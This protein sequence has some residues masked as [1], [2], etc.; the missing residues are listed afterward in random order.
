MI[1]LA[2]PIPFRLAA[3]IALALSALPAFLL[4]VNLPFYR[5]LPMNRQG[6]CG[7]SPQKKR[8]WKP[9]SQS[10]DGSAT[11]LPLPRSWS[12]RGSHSWNTPV[13]GNRTGAPHSQL[14]S[15]L[16][17]ARNEAE[18]IVPALQSVLANPDPNLEI[19]VLDDHSTDAT[20]DRVRAIA[21]SD[22]R[23]RLLSGDQ[24][25]PGWCGKQHACWQLARA[26]RGD[27]LIFM[28]ADVRLSADAL[29]R[30]R[31]HF[32][33]KPKTHLLSGV[34]RQITLGFAEKL[35]I[36]LIHFI[37]LGF[38]PMIAARLSLWPAFAAGCG[39]FF[40]ARR[41]AYFASDGHRA[42]RGSLHD[43]I[44]LPRTF[45]RHRF[46]TE[47]FD[48]TDIAACRMYM[49]CSAVW[50]GLGKNA[51]EGL[52]HP[53][54]ILPWTLVL[55]G[56]QVLPWLLLMGSPWLNTPQDA[57]AFTVVLAA[58]SLSLLPRLVAC[59]A[60]SQSWLGAV[61]HPLGISVLLAIQWQALA[62]RWRGQPMVWRGRR[63]PQAANVVA[64]SQSTA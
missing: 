33:H 32:E 29:S 6:G 16:I 61:L 50:H 54:A 2:G 49:S 28:D 58:A 34:P 13:P 17:P 23:V 12:Q 42:I 8:C 62:R 45:R 30:V 57:T 7:V 15:V 19:L 20:P 21:A 11:F 60:F 22:P 59:L 10:R 52:A 18:A 63:Y 1:D 35:L 38:L 39:Q 37:L 64:N 3:A 40:V 26:C 44:Q 48:A 5:R 53:V 9:N 46:Q 43:G 31:A 4:L 25:P 41:K 27:L 55:F 14:V 47:I 51:T 56:G 24:L 36:P